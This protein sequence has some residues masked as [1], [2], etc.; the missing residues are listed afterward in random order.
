MTDLEIKENLK[1]WPELIKKYKKPDKLKAIIQVV[2]SFGPYLALW[3]LMYFSLSWSYVLTIILAAINAF[4]LVR[5]FIIQHDCGHQSFFASQKWNNRIGFICSLFT[6]IPYKYWAKV[7]NYHHGHTGQLDHR[8]V[9]DIN[10][11]TVEE[12]R[13]LSPI[14]RFGYRIFRHPIFLFVVAP[15]LYIGISNRIP[16][17]NFKGWEKTRRSQII[18]NIFI[19]CIYAGLAFLIGWKKFLFIQLG[20]I[21]LFGIIAF[22]FFYV[23]H[24]HETTYMQWQKNWDYLLASIKGATY[25]KLPKLFHWLTGN[26]GYHHIHHLSSRIPNY[27]L[28]A[29]AKENPI[30]QKYVNAITFRESLKSMFNKLWD[31]KTQ[32]MITFKEFYRLELERVPQKVK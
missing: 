2:N 22:W 5:I 32:R 24:Q 28:A 17:F 9:G 15:T 1:N 8:D 7:H 11:L 18:N 16:I 26:I 4:F 21:F 10:F 23:Q 27:N 29:C 14:R 20:I 13:A 25:Y 19:L 12:Y 6:S 31:E 3:V 30:L